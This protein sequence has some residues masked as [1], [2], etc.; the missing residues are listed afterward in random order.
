MLTL[1]AGSSC[2]VCLEPF[3][4]NEKCPCSIVCGHVFCADCLHN[5][6]RPA[7]PLCRH[8]FNPN[9]TVKLHIELDTTRPSPTSAPLST[10]SVNAEQEARRLHEAIAGIADTGSTESNL[11]QLIED[12]KAFL[13]QQPRSL[14][15]DLRTAHQM[16][17]YLCEV[18]SNLRSQNE[19]VDTLTKQVAELAEQKADLAKQVED[20]TVLR[21][22]DSETAI[23][24]E[25]SL[26]DHCTKAHAAYEAMVEQYN[27]VTQEYASLNAE[28]RLLRGEADSNP[29]H[30][31]SLPGLNRTNL[32]GAAVQ[33]PNSHTISPLPQFT[34]IL[35]TGMSLFMPLPELEEDNG[36]DGDDEEEVEENADP[37][38]HLKYGLANKTHPGRSESPDYKF[39]YGY[40]H[41]FPSPTE[42]PSFP[43][44]PPVEDHFTNS[45][46][47]HNGLSRT[48]PAQE[49]RRS[50]PSSSASRRSST[51]TSSSAD[52]PRVLSSPKPQSPYPGSAHDGESSRGHVSMPSG[53]NNE[54]R[55]R[56]HDLLYDP[57]VSSSLP[58]MT[59]NHFPASL[60]HRD[61]HHDED[62][63]PRR[64]LSDKRIT[65][66]GPSPGP[67]VVDH[68]SHPS[69]THVPAPNPRPLTSNGSSSASAAAKAL[70]KAKK[71]QERERRRAEKERSKVDRDSDRS[72]T[73]STP[74]TS[75]PRQRER[76]S[77]SANAPWSSTSSFSSG[78][79]RASSNSNS[80]GSSSSGASL[81]PL[82]RSSSSNGPAS[83]G[84]GH[85]YTSA[86]SHQPRYPSAG[87]SKGLSSG[88][89]AFSTPGIYS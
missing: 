13:R 8:A 4:D 87:L 28:V 2:D 54:L 14:Y 27:V 73:N 81:P 75:H 38:E 56:L 23:A 85:G 60:T 66:A 35:N 44:P 30:R 53:D 67:S 76:A 45:P 20:L 25:V 18:K 31:N 49:R 16:I 59:P 69:M 22:V 5:L 32:R 9:L 11:R 88:S 43:I 6:T 61:S 71:E 65:Q 78:D 41:F 82:P 21:K 15:R 58:N 80:R 26:R 19:V 7:C 89:T 17:A 42:S 68:S 55:T 24:V 57:S 50:R 37:S 39:D 77:S 52:V 40:R 29:A 83:R 51:A 74:Q 47:A 86:A 72:R 63:A 84:T 33:N 12:G 70:E 1:G 34:G 36:E 10:T 48:A 79:S 62:Y 64:T 3:G 46:N